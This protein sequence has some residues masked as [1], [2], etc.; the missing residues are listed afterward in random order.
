MDLQNLSTNYLGD[1]VATP[2]SC[3]FCTDNHPLK[4]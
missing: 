1:S 2:L 3:R 4:Q